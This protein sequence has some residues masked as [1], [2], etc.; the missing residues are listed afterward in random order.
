[1]QYTIHPLECARSLFLFPFP[2]E[3]EKAVSVIEII[4]SI[5]D[6]LRLVGRGQFLDQFLP[7]VHLQQGV[8]ILLILLAVAHTPF[9]RQPTRDECVGIKF[10]EE[11]PWCG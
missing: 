3:Y 5:V 11:E 4:V 2:C 9:H 7:M 1:M 8:V 6:E 10:S